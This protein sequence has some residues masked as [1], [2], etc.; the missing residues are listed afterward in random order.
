MYWVGQ[1]VRLG[2]SIRYYGK[3]FMEILWKM[4]HKIL[5]KTQRNFLVNPVYGVIPLKKKKNKNKQ[6]YVHISYLSKVKA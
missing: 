5:W 3:I 2:F 4:Y 1:K 6:T